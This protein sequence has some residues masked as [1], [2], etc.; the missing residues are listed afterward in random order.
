MNTFA[1]DS[2]P[3][4]LRFS[5]VNTFAVDSLPACLRFSNMNTFAVDSLPACLR[6]S[7]MNTFCSRFTSCVL[8]IQ[9]YE[10]FC[11]PMVRS[12]V[13]WWDRQSYGLNDRPMAGLTVLSCYLTLCVSPSCRQLSSMALPSCRPPASLLGRP[14]QAGEARWRTGAM[15]ARATLSSAWGCRAVFT[16]ASSQLAR[17]LQHVAS[18]AGKVFP[19]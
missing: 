3:A 16:Q 1:V 8:T 14:A 13:L 9:Q 7:N 6:F 12:T 11:C 5:N 19:C 17:L 18:L 10:F 4:C 15:V 2:L